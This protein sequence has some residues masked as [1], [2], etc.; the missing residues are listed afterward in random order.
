MT[1]P[2]LT[3]GVFDSGVGGL[4]VL[5]A[6]KAQLPEARF[7]Y[8]GDMARLPYGTKSQQAIIAYTLKA[9]QALIGRGIQALVVAC[10][11]ASSCALPALHKAFPQL[12]VIDMITPTVA[13]VH[14]SGA[15]EVLVLATQGTVASHMYKNL[16]AKASPEISVHEVA[17]PLLVG[18]AEEGWSD[19]QVIH[20]ALSRYLEGFIHLPM[21][22]TV[23]LGC[24]HFPFHKAALEAYFG[25][26]VRV[27]DTAVPAAFKASQ[28]LSMFDSC[29]PGYSHGHPG[30]DPGS[31]D[32]VRSQIE[33]Q[34]DGDSLAAYL[35]T[36]S[37]E[38]FRSVA[39]LFLG[40][41]IPSEQ[42]ELIDL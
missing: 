29:H 16:F 24:T 14:A 33:V 1:H 21:I 3:I 36:D 42:V 4:T 22:D 18:L 38:R 27:V 41:A 31:H 30:L 40:T 26:Q 34:D 19:S 20:L 39:G 32:D 25:P 13:Q 35:V 17:T 5:R 9:T 23:I 8:L 15:K 2:P 7:I 6:L 28:L 12:P 11:T 37:P 10:S